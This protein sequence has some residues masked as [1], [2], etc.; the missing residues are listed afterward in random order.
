MVWAENH[1]LESKFG[2][3]FFCWCLRQN[4]QT[5]R[6]LLLRWYASTQK[7]TYDYAH[8]N[9]NASFS[10][11]VGNYY[12]GTGHPMKPHRIRM[13]HNLLLNYGLYKQ[14]QIF[15]CPPKSCPFCR[16]AYLLLPYPFQRPRHA[17]KQEMTQFHADDYVK[18]LRLITPDNMNEYTKQ[19]QRCTFCSA[20]S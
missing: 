8:H 17:T 9:S 2:A 13:T 18:F 4:E 6:V 11:D 3:R 12:Y 16:I 7:F 14:M 5:A 15:V 19:L 1:F 10:G 20:H